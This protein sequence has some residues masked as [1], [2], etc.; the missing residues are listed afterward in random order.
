MSAPDPAGSSARLWRAAATL[1]TGGALAQALPLLL[2]PW[3][4]R[5]Y[6]PAE[7]GAFA[8][9]SAVAA[10]LAVVAFA[11]YDFALPLAR[12]ETEARALLAL[13][14]RIGIGLVGVSALVGL[15]AAAWVASR[16]AQG[17]S[18]EPVPGGLPLALLWLLLPLAVGTSAGL[19]ALS[20]WAGRAGRFRRVAVSRVL[21]H[22]GGALSQGA[23]GTA[24]HAVPVLAPWGVLG[25]ALGAVLAAAAALPGLRRPAPQGGWL[26]VARVPAAEWRAVAATHRAFPWLNTPH[27]FL[28]A[29]QDAAAIGLVVV[30]TGEA[31]AGWWALALRYL[32]APAT[33]VGGSLSQALYPQLAAATPEAGLRLLR[34][35]V[36]ALAAAGLGLAAGL[37]LF[38]PALF[39]WAF[40]EAWAPAADLARALAPF[41]AAHFVASPL[42]VVT[43]AW[44]R[45]AWALKVAVAGQVLFLAALGLGLWQGGLTGAAWA[46]SAAMGLFYAGYAGWLVSGRLRPG[47]DNPAI[48]P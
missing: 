45:Q 36:A 29:L 23:L 8:L 22:G 38:G 40:G 12:D 21:Q 2:G 1:I 39:R 3:L 9:F 10:N 4:A 15:A 18:G 32:K 28:G 34:R 27:A 19:Q 31:A 47:D 37:A 30:V 17:A 44:R 42:G 5:L 11:R 48:R 13:C 26:A 24:I 43:L 25:L 41:V 14:G 46:V 16:P 35:T 33:L 20:L 7:W 6:S